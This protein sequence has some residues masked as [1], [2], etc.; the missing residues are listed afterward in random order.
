MEIVCHP[1]AQVGSSP[2]G[3][4]REFSGP[5]VSHDSEDSEVD[6]ACA[7]WKVRPG[8]HLVPESLHLLTHFPAG[9]YT[10]RALR[11]LEKKRLEEPVAMDLAHHHSGSAARPKPLG[12]L[13][14][15]AVRNSAPFHNGSVA[16]FY[17]TNVNREE[18][19]YFCGGKYPPVL[20]L[21]SGYF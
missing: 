3:R 6:W 10:R 5:R 1:S 7:S 2:E 15:E 14:P 16:P 20:T 13:G 19:S 21:P 17:L 11:H 4:H 12:Q 8:H 9:W 18:Q